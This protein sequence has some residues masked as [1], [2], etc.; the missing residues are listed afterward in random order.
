MTF[1]VVSVIDLVIKVD[2]YFVKYE[3]WKI[4]YKKIN[5]V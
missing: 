2:S 5:F 1:V 3:N 4:F